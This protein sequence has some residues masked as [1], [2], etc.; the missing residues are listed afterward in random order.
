MAALKNNLLF[1]LKASRPGLWFATGWLYLLPT[2][3]I[4]GISG[5]WVFWFGLF[6]TSFPLSLLVY[7][8]N[9]AV[10]FE[11]DALNPRKDSFWFGARGTK[12]QLKNIWKPILA[13]QLLTLP[14]LIWAGGWK[15]LYVFLAFLL[16]NALYNLPKKGL[17]GMPP[18]EL[19]AQIGYLLVVPLSVAANGT[20]QLPWQTYF[21][22]FLFAIQSHLIGEVM[23]IIP[24]RAA[25]RSTT[26][27]ILGLVKTKF[28]SIAIVCAEVLLLFITFKE[29]IFGG[30]LAL[31]VVWLLADVFLIYKNKTYSLSQMKILA[32]ASNVI[33]V[34]SIIYVW[35]SGCLLHVAQ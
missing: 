7:G 31:G 12:K 29:Y 28:L 16:V 8:W 15:V 1:Y 11:T 9:D 35:Y 20:S 10:D 22:L 2:S 3:Q 6:Y 19:F 14:V 24:D 33:A 27:T 21:Y 23:D 17:R 25:N 5:S 13:S 32:K 34:A 26:A 18:L 30:M 4:I